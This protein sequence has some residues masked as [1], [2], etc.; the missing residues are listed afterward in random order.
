MLAL[1]VSVMALAVGLSI[2]V[3]AIAFVPAF[4]YKW[5]VLAAVA[6]ILG[7][8]VLGVCRRTK[9]ASLPGRQ[10]W[11]RRIFSIGRLLI[12]VVLTFWLGLIFWSAV[13]PSGPVPPRKTNPDLIRVVSWNIHCGQDEG[14]PWKQFHWPARKDALREALDLVQPDI[15]SVQEAT[16][17]QVLF[18]EKALSGHD[19]VGVGRDGQAGGEHCAIYF[20]RDR[21][22]EI[23]GNTFWLEEPIDQPRPGSALDVKRICTWVRLRDRVNGR[24]LRIY[25]THLY[26]TEAPRLRAI[27]L[28]LAD[29]AAR[30]PADAVILTA[31]FNASPGVHSRRLF[32]EAGLRDATEKARKPTFH[33][34]YGIGVWSIDG[35]LVDPHWRVHHQFV[36]DIKPR[37]TFPS[38]HF[39]LL[40]DLALAE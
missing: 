8:L 22:E 7:W 26:L 29:I 37:N 35:I 13:C 3:A 5:W 33:F 15:L 23:D 18:I 25:N 34:F 4:G 28:I 32:L 30:D 21:F 1:V 38:D 6:A 39:G 36:L 31:D 14:P 16:P 24:T 9:H 17:E 12:I 2:C 19:R 27:Q 20:R 11:L 40:A 10:N